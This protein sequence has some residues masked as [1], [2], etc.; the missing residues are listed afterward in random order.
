MSARYAIYYCP[1]PDSSLW[2]L[3]SAW[4]GRDAAT[5]IPTSLPP[6]TTSLSPDL[7]QA[8]VAAP[9]RYGFHATLLAPFELASGQTE[10][11][12]RNKLGA[13]CASQTLFAVSLAVTPLRGFVALLPVTPEPRLDALAAACVQAFDDF[14]APLSAHDLAR[15]DTPELSLRQRQQ[16]MRWGYPYVFD[17]FRFHMSLTGPLPEQDLDGAHEALGK[18]FERVLSKPIGLSGLTLLKQADRASPF[19]W[20]EQFAFLAPPTRGAHAQAH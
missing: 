15:R 6:G 14:R 19:N 9:S 1:S 16:L 4:L 18:L 13:F 8:A 12:L 20:I 2:Q 5:G 3:G 7:I 17:D 10:A 11:A